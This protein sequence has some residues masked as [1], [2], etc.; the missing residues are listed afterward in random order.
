MNASLIKSIKAWKVFDSRGNPT[1]EI[2]IETA[3]GYGRAAAPSG[4]SRGKWEVEQYPPGGVDQ[5]VKI[6]ESSLADHIVGSDANRQ[7][8][9]DTLLH[10]VDGTSDFSKIGGNTAYATSIATALAASDTKAVPLFEHLSHATKTEL[11]LPLGNVLGGGRHARSGKTDIQEFLALPM[12]ARSFSEAA[13][14]NV[15]VHTEVAKLL[16]VEGRPATGKG[17]EGAWIADLTTEDAFEIVSKACENVSSSMGTTV[18]VGADMAASTLW[19]EKDKVYEY[20]KDGKRLSEE[21]QVDHVRGLIEKYKLVYVEDPF[22]EESFESFA[23]LTRLVRG[24]FICGDDLFV[25]NLA[26]LE[27]GRKMNAANAIIVKPNQVGTITDA[28]KTTRMAVDAGYV[29]VASH[30]S[31][32]TS[33]SELAHIA[34]AFGCPIIKTGVVG[35]ER[36]A[37]INELARIEKTF[38]E[39]IRLTKINR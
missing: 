28:L 8:E 24:T 35:G 12:R 16:E 11:P 38:R 22:H 10:E 6:V 25:T 36:V 14:A 9:I 19:N 34:I 37:K 32:D 7:E 5:A 29:T 30:R 4:A 1:I 20:V 18:S 31:G 39:K 13:Q 33:G 27:I 26:R 3:E 21:E 17:D 15:K 23:E 2:G